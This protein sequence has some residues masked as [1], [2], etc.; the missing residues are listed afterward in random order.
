LCVHI[1]P[2]AKPCAP[3]MRKQVQHEGE[4]E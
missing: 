1:R 3:V 4:C 2:I